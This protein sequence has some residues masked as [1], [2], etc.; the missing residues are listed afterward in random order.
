MT[1]WNVLNI[2]FPL[3]VMVGFGFF[4]DHV[5]KPEVPT[6]ESNE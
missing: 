1:V 3:A 2:V 4:L 6:E 5:S